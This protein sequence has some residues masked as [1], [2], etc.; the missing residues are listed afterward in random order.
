MF[1]WVIVT[2]T[3]LLWKVVSLPASYS[4]N[5]ECPALQS[6]GAWL[7]TT[8]WALSVSSGRVRRRASWGASGVPATRLPSPLRGAGEAHSERCCGGCAG[9]GTSLCPRA[10]VFPSGTSLRLIFQSYTCPQAH[11]SGINGMTLEV[12]WKVQSRETRPVALGRDAEQ[13]S[14]VWDGAAWRGF[15]VLASTWPV[16]G[17]WRQKTP[18]H[19]WFL[20]ALLLVLSEI[21]M[22]TVKTHHGAS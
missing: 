15:T 20:A 17:D 5:S 1:L 4:F 14:S 3:K 16:H 2:A 19:S 12:T 18:W 10:D 22:V 9:G 21:S 8:V 6:W 7:G 13:Q 11:G